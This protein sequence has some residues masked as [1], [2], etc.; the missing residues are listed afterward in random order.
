MGKYGVEEDCY[1][2][3]GEGG[4]SAVFGKEV[5]NQNNLGKREGIG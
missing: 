3:G 5:F 2:R 4:V 1:G